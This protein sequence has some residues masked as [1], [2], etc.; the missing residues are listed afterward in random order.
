MPSAIAIAAGGGV[1]AL[2]VR[3]VAEIVSAIN[4]STT[5]ALRELLTRHRPN[6]FRPPLYMAVGQ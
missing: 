1:N 2:T 4:P 3:R 5:E 6:N